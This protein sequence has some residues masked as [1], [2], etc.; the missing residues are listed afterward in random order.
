MSRTVS[1]QIDIYSVRQHLSENM[2]VNGR[3][4]IETG[5]RRE[6]IPVI[7]AIPTKTFTMPIREARSLVAA[8]TPL[9]PRT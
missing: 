9:K 6:S 4:V 5:G 7:A 8:A 3:I 1:L 2:S